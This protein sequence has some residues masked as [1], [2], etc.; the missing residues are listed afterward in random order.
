MRLFKS[1]QVLRFMSVLN[2]L[3]AN[4]SGSSA[5]NVFVP[6]AFV[7]VSITVLCVCVCFCHTATKAFI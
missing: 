2:V 4:A 7:K 5:E 3:S 6:E 1:E